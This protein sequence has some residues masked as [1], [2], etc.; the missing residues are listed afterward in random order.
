MSFNAQSQ[1]TKLSNTAILAAN[2]DNNNN[3]NVLPSLT[4]QMNTRAFWAFV[5]ITIIVLAIC[6]YLFYKG[7]AEMVGSRPVGV[8]SWLDNSSFVYVLFTIVGFLIAYSTYRACA[9]CGVTKENESNLIK[10]VFGMEAVLMIVWFYYFYRNIHYNN[11]FWASLALLAA[12]LV[13]FYMIWRVDR[14]AAYC[15]VPVV[16]LLAALAWASY[17]ARANN[18]DATKA[19]K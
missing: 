13:Q 9:C 14:I 17:K 8:W 6:F 19:R 5:I 18:T 16:L 10:I 4:E 1:L 11:A 12:S 7:K 2:N 15:H 3:N